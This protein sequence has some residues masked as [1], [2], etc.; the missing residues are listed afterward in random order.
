MLMDFD[1]SVSLSKV[2]AL[3]ASLSQF[4]NVD[5]VSSAESGQKEGSS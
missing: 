3:E 5:A 2:T 1:E 4:L